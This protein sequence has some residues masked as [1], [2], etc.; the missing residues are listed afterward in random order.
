MAN[1][2][3]QLAEFVANTTFEDIPDEVV[4]SGKKYL[5]DTLAC[6]FTGA[7]HP[8]SKIVLH[9]A[10]TNGGS[11]QASVFT[12]GTKSSASYAALVNGTMIGGFEL[13][14]VGHVSHPAGTVTPATLAIAEHAGSSGKD[15]LHALI[16]GY[17]VVCRIGDAQTGKV[18]TER[19]FH[20]PSAN[21]PFSAAAAVGKLLGFDSDTIASA[22][23]IAGSHAGG[24]VEYAWKG[25]MTKRMHLGRASQMGLESA[26]LAQGG[27]TG[28]ATI[29]EGSYGYL[30]AFSPAPKVDQLTDGL[31]SDWRQTTLIIKAYPCHVTAQAV[32]AALQRLKSEKNVDPSTIEKVHIRAG[33]RLLQ[34]RHLD[35]AP[36]SMMGAQYSLVYSTAIGAHRDL[37]DARQFDETVLEDPAIKQLAQNITWELDS[38]VPEESYGGILEVTAGGEVIT[39]DAT[40]FVGSLATP[41]NMDDVTDKF[42]RYSANYLNKGQQDELL[43]IVTDIDK[44]ADLSDLARLMRAE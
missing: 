41:A 39:V 44:A 43:A 5:L 26:L 34:E 9:V 2:T 16:L 33:E 42:Y 14:H 13:E 4:A 30:Q 21:G 37:N 3:R 38:S 18:E 17:E 32:V 20:N 19:G 6:G 31:G 27:F 1:E 15:F 24:L 12:Q 10:Q 7:Q 35:R 36:T 23:G 11:E 40:K 25:E 22:M 8:W 28:P 29:L